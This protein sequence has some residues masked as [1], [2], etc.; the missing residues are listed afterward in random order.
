MYTITKIFLVALFLA[1]TGWSTKTDFTDFD[2]ED[3]I[4]SKI[5]SNYHDVSCECNFC[6]EEESYY[7]EIE[8]YDT[9]LRLGQD[10]TVL[11]IDTFQGITCITLK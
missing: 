8:G 3:I 7:M 1:F 2:S 10:L 11:S 6:T 5:D 4:Y 9:T